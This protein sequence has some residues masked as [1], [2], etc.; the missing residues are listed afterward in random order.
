MARRVEDL[1][2]AE[3][4]DP[5]YRTDTP[6]FHEKNRKARSLALKGDRQPHR[7]GANH[8]DIESLFARR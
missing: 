7:A 1:C 6:R 8:A 2:L 3:T 4:D 5:A